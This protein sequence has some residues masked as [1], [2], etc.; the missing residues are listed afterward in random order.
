MSHE[1]M[2]AEFFVELS[3]NEQELVAGG[4]GPSRK[5]L[6]FGPAPL[7]RGPIKRGLGGKI[8]FGSASLKEGFE[9]KGFD[10]FPFSDSDE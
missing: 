5:P 3:E 4:F 7:G 6:P 2:K 10:G 8:P 9:D 1:I